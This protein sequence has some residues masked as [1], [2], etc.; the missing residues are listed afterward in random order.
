MATSIVFNLIFITVV[1]MVTGTDLGGASPMEKAF[2]DVRHQRRVGLFSRRTRDTISDVPCLSLPFLTVLKERFVRWLDKNNDGMS[3]FDEVK[4]HLRRFKPNVK[5]DA[6]ESFIR[7][8]DM[9]GNQAIDF[10]PEYVHDMS[11]PD[12]TIEGAKEWFHLQ[13]TND[14]GFVNE[15]ELIAVAEAV[16]TSPLEAAD[17]VQGYYMVADL[18]KDGK[19]SFD[20]FKT[21]YSP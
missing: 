10:V 19:L 3:T 21:L 12:Y 7:R 11:A 16:G 1:V 14:D 5:D 4:D 8:R 13:D 20:E 15:K 17:T 6:V 2:Q 9:N 18:D